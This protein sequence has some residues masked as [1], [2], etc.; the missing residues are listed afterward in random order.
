MLDTIKPH[1]TFPISLA[2]EAGGAIQQAVLTISD[3]IHLHR[4]K[5]KIQAH[6]LSN[7]K[8][9]S[10][11]N[12]IIRPITFPEIFPIAENVRCS[13]M[14]P[15]LRNLHQIIKVDHFLLTYSV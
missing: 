7:L 10:Y 9:S 4:E 1:C 13:H 2:S 3:N 5:A 11:K 14:L 12:E 15:S 8:I 6:Y